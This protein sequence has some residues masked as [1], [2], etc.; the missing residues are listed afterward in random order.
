MP[1]AKL[2]VEGSLDSNVLNPILQGNPILHQGGSKNALKPRALV[3]RRE[4]QVAAGYLRDRDFDFDPPPDLSKPTLDYKYK[5]TPIGWRWCRHEI[6]N[7]LIEPV[8]VSEAMAWPI[9]DVEE[10]IC[11]AG[12]KIRSYEAARWTVGIVRRALPPHYELETRPAVLNE[13]ALPPALDSAAVNAW[14]SNNIETH[15][16]CLAG[17]TDPPLA[18]RSFETFAARFDEAFVADVSN[19]LLWFSGKDILA[20]MAEWL[21]I[22]AGANPGVFRAAMRDWIIAHPERALEL[23]PEWKSLTEVIRA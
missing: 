6:E 12:R 19:V 8:I 20:G 11:Q 9:S 13:I 4:N 15:R 14:A 3:D 2:F 23:L 10:A 7:Y 5:D 16:S 21:S 18:H 1:L 22:K 17:V